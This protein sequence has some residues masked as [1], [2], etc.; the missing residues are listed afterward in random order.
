MWIERGGFECVDTFETQTLQTCGLH[1]RKYRYSNEHSH[2]EDEK[3]ER[4]L[5]QTSSLKVFSRGGV[6]EE[7]F[8]NQL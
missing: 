1:D 8:K 4:L 2:A 7:P 6:A 5:T 3:F